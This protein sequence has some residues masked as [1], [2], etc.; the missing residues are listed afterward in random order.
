[1]KLKRVL[2]LISAVGLLVA[3]TGCQTDLCPEARELA[4]AAYRRQELQHYMEAIDSYRD[5][6]QQEGIAGNARKRIDDEINDLTEVFARRKLSEADRLPAE[7]VQQ[8]DA[9]IVDLEQVLKYD[10]PDR[11][12][13]TELTRYREKKQELADTVQRL[14]RTAMD[15]KHALQW[16]LAVSSIDRALALDAANAEAKDLRWKTVPER[17]SYYEREVNSLCT[18]DEWRKAAALL[19]LLRAEKPD[20]NAGFVARLDEL[21]QTT[22]ASVVRSQAEELIREKKYYSAYD[23]IKEANARQCEDLL[24]TIIETGGNYYLTLTNDEY[25]NVREFRAYLAAVKALELLGLDHEQAFKLHRDLE[26]RVDDSIQMKIGIASFDSLG[27]DLGAGKEFANELTSHLYGTLPYG[28]KIDERQK[29]EFGI[30][31]VGSAEM[32]RLLGLKWAVFGD[33]QCNMVREREERQVTTFVHIPERVPNPGYEGERAKV[34]LDWRY[35]SEE[36]AEPFIT[37]TRTEKITY[38]TGQGSI[39]GLITVSPRLYSAD[40]SALVSPENFA[41]TRQVK[42]SFSDEVVDA[43]IAGDPLELPSELEFMRQLRQEM[44]EKV[45]NWLLANFGERHKRYCQQADHFIQRREWDQ[46]V[47]AAAQGYLYCIRDNVPADDEW[48]RRLRN[49]A[50]FTLTEETPS[51]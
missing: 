37:T 19:D 25:R 4:E 44:V 29:I 11:A 40:Q 18:A 38:Q 9:L 36:P 31:K 48:F 32:V 26:D 51:G 20:P 13:E 5:C 34:G 41:V 21:M 24:R 14:L 50:L 45:G 35:A 1:M 23:L 3:V 22:K 7:T 39:L 10:T 46:A 27:D 47:R 42:D 33:I 43:N 17:D 28:I 6:C 2:E 12:I 15:Q 49:M 8:C 30:E 16:T